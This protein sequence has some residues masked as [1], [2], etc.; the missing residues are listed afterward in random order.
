M[1]DGRTDG[2]TTGRQAGSFIDPFRG[3]ARE[4]DILVLVKYQDGAGKHYI[5]TV[6]LPLIS[7]S[8]CMC[9]PVKPEASCTTLHNQETQPADCARK[10][11]TT[12]RFLP[13]GETFRRPRLCCVV[14]CSNASPGHPVINEIRI[15]QIHV[16]NSVSNLTFF[17]CPFRC[18]I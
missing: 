12:R 11:S 18:K 5:S 6:H 2:R 3:S 4:T 9:I 1:T 7:Q 8:T 14:L 10:E 16:Q 17:F 13:E 15:R